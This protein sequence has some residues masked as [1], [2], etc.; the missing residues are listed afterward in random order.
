MTTEIGSSSSPFN[1]PPPDAE[2]LYH[3]TTRTMAL[4]IKTEGL[5]TWHQ[6]TESRFANPDG[7]FAKNRDRRRPEKVLEKHREFFAELC[8][9]I[10]AEGVAP[11]E[12]VVETAKRLMQAEAEYG[13]W[14]YTP[15]GQGGPDR[16][17]LGVLQKAKQ[18]EYWHAVKGGLDGGSTSGK[19]PWIPGGAARDSRYYR[20]QGEVLAKAR[21]GTQPNHFASRYAA[22]AADTYYA[23][24]ESVVIHHIYFSKPGEDASTCYKDYSKHLSS[25]ELALLR[26][27]RVALEESLEEDEAETRAEMTKE[28]V[29]ASLIEVMRD[30]SKFNDMRSRLDPKNWMPIAEMQ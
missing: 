23:I 29:P 8:K 2:W 12:A 10:A 15:T 16:T 27:K 5:K 20:D 21:Q 7:A 3:L 6:A 14:N 13:P 24:E 17:Q 9:R 18:E 30:H 19:Q 22:Q 11:R 1:A 28:K 4:R 26:V 25:N